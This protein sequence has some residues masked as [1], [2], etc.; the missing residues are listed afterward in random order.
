M[1]VW[2]DDDVC[3]STSRRR[4][5]ETNRDFMIIDDYEKGR[6]GTNYVCISGTAYDHGYPVYHHLTAICETVSTKKKEGWT[7]LF[8]RGY[9]Y[10]NVF[11]I[12]LDNNHTRDIQSVNTTQGFF[13]S[14]ILWFFSFIKIKS[15]FFR[16]FLFLGT[17]LCFDTCDHGW[18]DDN[19]RV[20]D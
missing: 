15:L 12:Q 14:S 18:A 17:R 5:E 7:V 1:N 10:Q 20:V 13:T 16:H 11:I 4:N 8:N 3:D 2:G 6:S 9:Y 19:T